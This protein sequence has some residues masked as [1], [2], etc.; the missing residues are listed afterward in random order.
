MIDTMTNASVR[1]EYSAPDELALRHAKPILVATDESVVATAAIRAASLISAKLGVDTR[2]VSVIEPMQ[3]LIPTPGAFMQSPFI[4][5]EQADALKARVAE[6]LESAG[7]SDGDWKIDVRFGR[8]ATEIREAA[9][10]M[11]AQLVI[12]GL[13]HRGA[14]DRLLEGETALDVLRD[15]EIPVFLAAPEIKALPS[16]VL[17]AVD[18]TAHS[19]A[20]AREAM[21]F[22]S[23]DARIYL[24][25]VKPAPTVFDGTSLWEEDYEDVARAELA[26]FAGLLGVPRTMTVEAVVLAG[27]PAQALVEFANMSHVDMIAAGSHGTGMMRRIFVGSVATGILHRFQGGSV[28]IVPERSYHRENH[29]RSSVAAPGT[30]ASAARWTVELKEFTSR[31]CSRPVTLEIDEVSIGAQREAVGMPLIGVDFDVRMGSAQIMLGG[32][33]GGDSHLTH[34]VGPVTSVDLLKHADGSD[35]ALKIGH[36]GGQILITLSPREP[37]ATGKGA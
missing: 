8:P 12:I 11:D 19:I 29:N 20:A 1:P 33:A 32:L 9:K 31:N 17:I 10:E 22:V 5:P 16:R 27:R 14:V 4:A 34:T 30:A 18:F 35:H 36:E 15:A 37:L 6:Q 21:R 24:V 28:L 25:H 26:R 3:Y 7:I 2:V 13:A 23:N